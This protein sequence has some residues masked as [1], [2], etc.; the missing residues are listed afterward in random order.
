MS[1]PRSCCE[2]GCGELRLAA[3]N[4]GRLRA[5]E[6]DIPTPR[7]VQP[8]A[9]SGLDEHR[10]TRILHVTQPTDAGVGAVVSSLIAD[11]LR[12]GYRVALACPAH[13]ELANDARSGGATVYPWEARRSPGVSTLG[14]VRRLSRIVTAARPD[15]VVLHSA[16]AGLAGRLAIRRALPT[17]YVPHAWS[18][19]AVRGLM[20]RLALSWEKFAQRWTTLIV[21]VC[22]DERSRGFARGI[23]EKLVVIRNGVDLDALI[24]RSTREARRVL[25]LQ[26]SPSAVCVGRLTRQKGQDLLVAAWPTVRAAVPNAQLYLVGDGPEREKLSRIAGAG[27]EVIGFRRDVEA[28][29][30]AADVAVLPS[31]WETMSLVT[32]EAMACARGVVSFA[33]DGAAEGIGDTG[34]ILPI[35]D[36]YGLAAALIARLSD[37]RTA[38]TEGARARDRVEEIG[39]V[40]RTLESWDQLITRV[41]GLSGRVPQ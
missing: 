10:T 32:L 2:R 21:C 17:V 14:E 23:H 28:W 16:K 18:F 19:Q 15:V 39:D 11:Q 33:F 12:R 37:V 9:L 13:G 30:A 35:G 34:A 4:T 36:T 1:S 41:A 38:A 31:R 3:T 24:P 27:V 25:G 40:R 6:A 26:E 29:Y 8:S 20:R 7:S 5:P 22:E